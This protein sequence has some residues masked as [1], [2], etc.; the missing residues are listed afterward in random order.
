MFVWSF[1][2]NKRELIIAAAGMALFIILAAV[3]LVR[4]GAFRS[5][6]S[7]AEQCAATPRERAEYLENLGWEIEETP[8][9]VREVMIPQVFD[10]RFEEYSSLQSSQGFDIEKLRGSRVKL[11]T[12]R[13]TNYPVENQ[14]MVAELL[15]RNGRIVGGDICQAGEDGLMQGFDP[16]QFGSVAAKIQIRAKAAA[17]DRTVPDAIPADSDALPE[18]DSDGEW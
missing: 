5:R 9:S 18:P 2:L 7:G 17:I 14:S 6:D 15:V 8:L 10:G 4:G 3:L 16:A 13:V 11:Y 1:K 12:Y